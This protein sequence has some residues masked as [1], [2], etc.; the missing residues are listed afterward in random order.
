MSKPL[1]IEI[2]P[3]SGLV[4]DF[5]EAFKAAQQGRSFR[6]RERVYFTSLKPALNFLTRVRLNPCRRSAQSI[7]G[8]FMS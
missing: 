2:R 4:D 6:W 8:P 3:L 1:T 5:R 7:S